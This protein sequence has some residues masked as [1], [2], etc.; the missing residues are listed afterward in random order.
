[1]E[2]DETI[3][4]DELIEVIRPFT[5]RA[6]WRRRVLVQ[7]HKIMLFRTQV[8][9]YMGGRRLKKLGM[10]RLVRRPEPNYHQPTNRA[11]TPPVRSDKIWRWMRLDCTGHLLLSNTASLCR[12]VASWEIL[13]FHICSFSRIF[14]R[15]GAESGYLQI[16]LGMLMRG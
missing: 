15:S 1:M 9:V 3:E 14:L 5:S 6:L 13:S 4:G 8:I 11:A 12:F 16:T 2:G 10:E 7:K